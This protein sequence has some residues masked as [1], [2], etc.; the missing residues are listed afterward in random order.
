M[1]RISIFLTSMEVG[2]AQRIAQ[3]LCNGFVRVGLNVDLVLVENRGN[4]IGGLRD[5]VTVIDLNASRVATSIIPLRQYL[6]DRTPEVLY[7][8][9]TEINIAAIIAHQLAG[10][11]TR[12]VISEHNTLTKSSE[13]LK[14]QLISILV[15]YTYFKADQI[16]CVSEGVRKD[17]LNVVK[18][19]PNEVTVIHN[20]INVE[21]IRRRAAEPLEHEWLSDPASSI[22]MSA[23]RH[24]PQ[25]GFDTLLSAFS[26]LNDPNTRLLVLGEGPETASLKKLANELGIDTRVDF[27]GFVDNPYKYM[28]RADVFVLSSLYEGFGNV[29]VEAM[30]TG[31]PVVSTDCPSGPAEILEGGRYGPLVPVKDPVAMAQA[32]EDTIE[33][34]ISESTLSS[35][36]DD[37]STNSIVEKYLDVLIT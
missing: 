19:P 9:M 31:C 6:R 26:K 1:E 14:D 32:I 37:F 25:K 33:N 18:V 20:P 34:P 11:K 28:A 15:Q 16:I 3:N 29:L 4:L 10:A 30:A 36:A 35:R 17:L 8:M 27:P 12:L 23:G 24:E 22:V 5:E 13:G 2:G 21:H 7:S